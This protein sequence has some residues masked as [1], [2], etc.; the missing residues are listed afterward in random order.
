[1]LFEQLSIRL[2]YWFHWLL[3]LSLLREGVQA[4]VLWFTLLFVYNKK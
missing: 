2:I 1:M 4:F 3:M